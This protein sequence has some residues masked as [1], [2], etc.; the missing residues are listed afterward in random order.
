MTVLALGAIVVLAL[1]V[2]LTWALLRARADRRWAAAEQAARWAD[3]HEAVGGVTR[4]LVRRAARLPS[5]EVRVLGESVIDE[6]ADGDPDWHGRFD[7]ARQTAID[8]AI[9]LNGG[10]YLG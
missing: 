10:S 4:V 8:R 2:G 7:R 9:D 5:G 6:V 3:T 1:L